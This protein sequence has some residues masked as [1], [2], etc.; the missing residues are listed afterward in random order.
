MCPCGTECA[1]IPKFTLPPEYFVGA[2]FGTS[3]WKD[4]TLGSWGSLV[5]LKGNTGTLF[6]RNISFRR[7]WSSGIF[8]YDIMT[9]M[10][11][12]FIW[13][14]SISLWVSTHPS[15]EQ[16]QGK[17]F[18]KTNFWTRGPSPQELTQVCLG[19]QAWAVSK[20]EAGTQLSPQDSGAFLII[21]NLELLPLTSQIPFYFFFLFL[22]F[23]FFLR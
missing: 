21:F 10:S 15:A 1:S 8:L 11:L 13:T 6:H 18:R 19:T 4:T 7:T 23:S 14:I 3:D 17:C 22:S 12:L 20:P 2:H 9:C 16:I 5:I